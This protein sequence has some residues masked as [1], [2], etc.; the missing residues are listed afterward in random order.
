MLLSEKKYVLNRLEDL[1][2]RNICAQNFS[3]SE[4][5]MKG[6]RVEQKAEQSKIH[7]NIVV[8]YPNQLQLSNQTN[9]IS[10][11]SYSYSSISLK[12]SYFYGYT[13]LEK[14]TGS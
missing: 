9:W 8:I 11:D 7:Y 14:H 4:I 2:A 12:S 10:K 5:I 6:F 1:L 13:S 3:V